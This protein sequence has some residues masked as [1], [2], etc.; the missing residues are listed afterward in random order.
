MKLPTEVKL[1]KQLSNVFQ[2]ARFLTA[3][4]G[5][6]LIGGSVLLGLFF[7]GLVASW[8]VGV[9]RAVWLAMTTSLGVVSY[10]VF[11]FVRKTT[12]AIV[13]RRLG[14][15]PTDFYLTV[16]E[17]LTHPFENHF[18]AQAVAQAAARFP[19]DWFHRVRPK[20]LYSAGLFFISTLCVTPTLWSLKSR[21]LWP[22]QAGWPPGLSSVHPG[23]VLFPRGESVKISVK[24]TGDTGEPPLL[25]FQEEGTPW[26]HRNF[27]HENQIYETVFESL[28]EKLAYR[29]EHAGQKT[30]VFYLTPFDAP[31]LSA[32]KAVVFPPPH[33]KH[34]SKAYT[35]SL[36]LR[37]PIGSRVQW[38]L[39]TTPPAQN[40]FIRPSPVFPSKTGIPLVKL[41]SNEWTFEDSITKSVHRRV[42]S[43]SH[44]VETLVADLSI[45]ALPDAPPTIALLVPAWD[46]QAAVTDKIPVQVNIT[47]DIGPVRWSLQIKVNGVS[48]VSH[49]F[50]LSSVTPSLIQEQE[51]NLAPL[52]LHPGDRVD[53]T[54]WAWDGGGGKSPSETRRVD[55]V[56]YKEEHARIEKELKTF[57]RD[58]L[59]RAEEQQALRD[60]VL[61]S[62]P[63]WDSLA[64][65]QQ[66]LNARVTQNQQTLED[67]LNRMRSD[68]ET[69]QIL[70]AEQEAVSSQLNDLRH[71]LSTLEE[72][73][74][75]QDPSTSSAEMQNI[76]KELQRLSA[77]SK[78]SL[79]ARQSRRQGTPPAGFSV[80]AGS[81]AQAMGEANEALKN[82]ITRQEQILEKTNVLAQ[83]ALDS[84]VPSRVFPPLTK[85]G[86][87][88]LPLSLS[89]PLSAQHRSSGPWPLFQKKLADETLSLANTLKGFSNI[90][91]LAESKNHRRLSTA[92]QQMTQSAVF[93]SS[94][95][96]QSAQVQQE[97]SLV[98]LREAQENLSKA[99]KKMESLAQ[100][101]GQP[102]QPTFQSKSPS[103]APQGKVNIPKPEAPRTPDTFRRDLMDFMDEPVPP[104]H[105]PLIQDYR[106]HWTK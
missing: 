89:R 34:P 79:Q 90:T 57:Q 96:F 3:L 35:D 93:L 105:A 62:T 64:S 4:Q 72:N 9:Q 32:V 43:T 95:T 78:N 8:G 60:R 73:L 25:Y 91:A 92:S 52:N 87:G 59:K 56:S 63:T 80:S 15:T 101:G 75:N 10:F 69:D 98:L 65:D 14:G 13:F 42:W 50:L 84:G 58:L 17:L 24:L 103:L 30:P 29:V 5:F 86:R 81:L 44:G 16:W 41:V 66:S 83:T 37:V 23:S 77:L 31:R 99:Q 36:T 11:Q 54:A 97:Q 53:L 1:L 74:L 104:E 82:I 20:G 70:W 39:K 106:R 2:T 49:S 26:S 28:S 55:I 18:V 7:V 19:A 21:V 12:K 47:D 88:D 100:S 22:F 38:F 51:L 27:A 40:L 33:T 6:F 46:S 68:P 71:D 85:G 67:L 48:R 61:V 94:E 45:E 102:V 76:I